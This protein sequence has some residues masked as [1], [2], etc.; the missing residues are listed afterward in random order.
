MNPFETI[1]QSMARTL[2]VNVWMNQQEE[3]KEQGQP[4]NCAGPGQDWMDIAPETTPHYRDDALRL[5]GM[6]EGL[7]TRGAGLCDG[8]EI[9][10]YRAFA[11]DGLPG[12]RPTYDYVKDFGH[13][14]VMES[15][16]HGVSWTDDHKDIGLKLPL[17][18]PEPLPVEA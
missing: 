4:H 6:I 3:L 1:I 11:A 9:W 13:Y 5:A 2:W 17:I 10:V 15:L 7:N 16:G 18:C 8:L 12:I 14:L